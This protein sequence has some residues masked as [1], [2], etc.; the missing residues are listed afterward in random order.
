MNFTWKCALLYPVRGSGHSRCFLPDVSPKKSSE[1]PL[2]HLKKTTNLWSFKKNSNGSSNVANWWLEADW[3]MM[4]SGSARSNSHLRSKSVSND[5]SLPQI[6]SFFLIIIIISS[7]QLIKNADL[8]FG[9]RYIYSKWKVL[10]LSE[11]WFTRSHAKQWFSFLISSHWRLIRINFQ[12]ITL[13]H[14]FKLKSY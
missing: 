6:Y 8:R 14:N 13:K 4:P 9:W 12:N 2:F 10:L 5:R 1:N 7:F 3:V 11:L